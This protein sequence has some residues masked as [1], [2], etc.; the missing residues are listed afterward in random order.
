MTDRIDI[1]VKLDVDDDSEAESEGGNNQLP[2]VQSTTVANSA[3]V[4]EQQL[5]TVVPSGPDNQNNAAEA[6]TANGA[7]QQTQN[8][9]KV[10]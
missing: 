2:Q 7:S 8:Q 10:D 3:A 1:K 6:T 9:A 4:P 5:P